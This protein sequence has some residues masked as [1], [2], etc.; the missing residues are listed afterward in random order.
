M[1]PIIVTSTIAGHLAV[2][3]ADGRV[4]GFWLTRCCE[5]AVTGVC[6]GS[7]CKGCYRR[8]DARLGFSW[9]WDSIEGTSVLMDHLE[10]LVG[11]PSEWAFKLVH[12]SAQLALARAA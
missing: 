11:L 6:E 4:E 5:A 12:S 9:E 1:A 10:E 8:V 2:Q 3:V 7:V